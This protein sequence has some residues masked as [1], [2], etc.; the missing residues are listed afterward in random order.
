MFNQRN[1]QF[2]NNSNNHYI[3]DQISLANQIN[4]IVSKILSNNILFIKSFKNKMN[5]GNVY[6]NLKNNIPQFGYQNINQ[7]NNMYVQDEIDESN[8]LDLMR[9]LSIE[10]SNLNANNISSFGQSLYGIN[11]PLGM[12]NWVNTQSQNVRPGGGNINNINN[13]NILLLKQALLLKLLN[14]NNNQINNEINNQI[15]NPINERNYLNEIIAQNIVNNQLNQFQNNNHQV[16]NYE[17]TNLNKFLGNFNQ[18]NSI[19]ELNQIQNSLNFVNNNKVLNL[20]NIKLKQQKKNVLN[21]N[22]I[23]QLNNQIKLNT[24]KNQNIADSSSLLNKINMNKNILYNYYN[25]NNSLPN[26]N[27]I[28]LNNNKNNN[29]IL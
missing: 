17:K 2:V 6:L 8:L 4:D 15:N 22:N 7:N 28:N 13:N 25:Q 18:S 29:S 24:L 16:L 21:R 9:N 14:N 23:D 12:S 20:N 3:E 19:N 26:N 11:T 27:N 5:N 1:T 10:P